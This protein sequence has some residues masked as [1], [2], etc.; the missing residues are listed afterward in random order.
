M[1]DIPDRHNHRHIFFNGIT[2]GGKSM[3]MFH[4]LWQKVLKGE[5]FCLID[6][7]GDTVERLAQK[8]E[9]HRQ[10]VSPLSYWNIHY[11]QPGHNMTFMYDPFRTEYTGKDYQ[12]WLPV[13]IEHVVKT[14]ARAYGEKNLHEQARRDRV[15]RYVMYFVGT[16]HKDGTHYGV[17][18][19]LEA[20]DVNAPWW[21][22]MFGRVRDYLPKEVA[23]DWIF[24]KQ[25]SRHDFWG[26]TESTSNWLTRFLSPVVKSVFAG[27]NP[28]I[29]FRNIVE[30][31]GIILANLRPTEFF[32]REQ[33]N[34]FAGLL[35]NEV[36]DATERK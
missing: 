19:A 8:I 20:L 33:G 23:Q 29:S 13:R 3:L 28:P 17:H 14:I 2:G 5:G 22:A 7:L 31:D 30:S 25:M 32:S 27:K 16:N 35:V 21:P 18:R 12:N 34:V 6:P 36:I 9:I 1:N 11:L 10:K 4:L 15:L 24:M 26:F